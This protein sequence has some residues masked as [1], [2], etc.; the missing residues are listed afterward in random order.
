MERVEGGPV[1]PDF[2]EQVRTEGLAY[3][4]TVDPEG[5]TFSYWR[6]GEFLQFTN[7]ETE[8]ISYAAEK[9]FRMYA[10]AAQYVIDQADPE[11]YARFGI[12]EWA[13]PIIEETWNNS[14]PPEAGMRLDRYYPMLYGRFDFALQRDVLGRVIGVKLLEYNA[15]TPTGMVET[16]LTQWNWFLQL[17]SNGANGQ[18]N[19]LFEKLVDGWVIEVQ[20]LMDKTD[21]MDWRGRKQPPIIHCAYMREEDSGEDAL[22]TGLMMEAAREAARRMGTPDKPAFIVKSVFVEE[23]RRT[24]LVDDD[25]GQPL[26]IQAFTVNVDP[27]DDSERAKQET[28]KVLFKL[29]PWEWIWNDQFGELLCNAIM[30]G[31]LVVVEPPFKAL[32][33]NKAMLPILWELFGDDPELREFLL[34]AY[35]EDDPQAVTLESYVRKAILGREGADSTVVLNGEVVEEAEK[36]G[37]GEEGFIVQQYC[38]LPRFPSLLEPGVSFTVVVGVWTVLDFIVGLCARQSKTLIT[39][40]QSGFLPHVVTDANN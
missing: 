21:L 27:D 20:R 34:P 14:G 30:A 24:G 7:A 5:N 25:T 19:E 12:P 17:H 33:S 3:V 2:L 28:I 40:N 9:L 39:D 37:Y 18:W 15:D 29:Y 11:L 10:D 1:R 16:A 13:I 4:Q 32:Y 6:E 8:I 38:E 26:D 22:N 36:Q 31:E 35:F 23:I